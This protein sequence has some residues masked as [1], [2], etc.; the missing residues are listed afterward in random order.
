[1]M[2]DGA[3]LKCACPLI[4]ECAMIYDEIRNYVQARGEGAC[5]RYLIEAIDE[6]TADLAT[7]ELVQFWFD[8]VDA[9]G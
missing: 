1:M 8:T 9:A 7:R 5:E 2:A 6:H 4:E 3:W